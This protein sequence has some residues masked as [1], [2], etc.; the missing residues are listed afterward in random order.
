MGVREG[1]QEAAS[2]EERRAG[3]MA[4]TLGAG[5]VA[6]GLGIATAAG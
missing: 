4:H 6:L 3:S 2:L 5:L 1:L